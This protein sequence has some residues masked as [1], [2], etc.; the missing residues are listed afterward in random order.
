METARQ[1]LFIKLSQGKYIVSLL[2]KFSSD[3]D[4][5]KNSGQKYHILYMYT[6]IFHIYI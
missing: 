1:N 2:R 5:H 4:K 3:A 6:H